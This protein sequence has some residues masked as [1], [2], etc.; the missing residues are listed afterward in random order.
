MLKNVESRIPESQD[1][2]GA[3]KE[4]KYGGRCSLCSWRLMFPGNGILLCSARPFFE[5]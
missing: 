5:P 4:R 3:P 2:G 1:E